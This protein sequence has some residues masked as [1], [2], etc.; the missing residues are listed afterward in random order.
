MRPIGFA[1]LGPTDGA[2]V[3]GMGRFADN[4]DP[5][6]AALWLHQEG[7]RTVISIEKDGAEIAK[8]AFESE[9]AGTRWYGSFLADWHAPSVEH[10]LSPGDGRSM[11]GSEGG[12]KAA[13]IVSRRL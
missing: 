13:T 11:R 2:P 7:V 6:L 4:A 5:R 8:E 9:S 12:R 1:W 10:L 3:A